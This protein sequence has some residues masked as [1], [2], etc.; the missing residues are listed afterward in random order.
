MQHTFIGGGVVNHLRQ[1]AWS[2]R[3]YR[4]S[5]AGYHLFRNCVRSLCTGQF[6]FDH[7]RQYLQSIPE[8]QMPSSG[9]ASISDLYSQLERHK[10]R[11]ECGRHAV[12]LPPQENLDEFLGDVT[13]SYPPD[14]GFKILKTLG[15]PER[16]SYI[17]DADVRRVAR[18]MIGPVTNQALAANALFALGLGPPCYGV[19]HLKSG[20]NDLTAFAVRHVEGELASP[21]ECDEFVATMERW[22]ARRVFDLVPSLGLEDTDFLPPNCNRNLIRDWTTGT[23]SYVDFQRFLPRQRVLLQELAG[24]S[25]RVLHFGG[26]SK[27]FRRGRKYL[28]QTI[29]GLPSA[30]KRDTSYRW[31]RFQ[32]VLD[33]HGVCL[34]GRVVFDVCCNCGMLLAQ[35]LANGAAWGVGWDLPAVV[36]QAEKIMAAVGASRASLIPAN[37]SPT[38][39]LAETLPNWLRPKMEDS[40]VFYLAAIEH[41][42]VIRDLGK[43]PWKALMFEGHQGETKEQV[44]SNLSEMQT[45]WNCHV[46]FQG[47]LSD[48]DCGTRAFALLLR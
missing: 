44:A 40:V 12:Y 25:A 9:V 14:T 23:L 47:K 31:R 45:T 22:H 46:A 20:S 17:V 38:Y 30:A 15:P 41:V 27:L 37:L 28:Y 32:S 36:S 10:I 26:T 21:E 48:G 6:T 5:R 18:H 19:V 3:V 29:P 7:K 34:D 43:L 4:E 1:Y 33:E 13:D 42:G 39:K 2:K 35:A 8:Y 24:A 11:H 16:V